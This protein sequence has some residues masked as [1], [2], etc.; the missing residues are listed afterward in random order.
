MLRVQQAHRNIALQLAE[1]AERHYKKQYGLSLP[2]DLEDAYLPFKPKLPE[3][4]QNSRR[5]AN[6]LF[7]KRATDCSVIPPIII[8]EDCETDKPNSTSDD[9]TDNTVTLTLPTVLVSGD[10]ENKDPAND[11]DSSAL[12]DVTAVSDINEYSKSIPTGNRQNVL[13]NENLQ[14][15]ESTITFNDQEIV[16]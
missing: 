2:D 7:D 5:R 15:N 8:E 12:V 3:P 13:S 9:L 11:N 4:K 16:N 1:M 10:C 14:T 6:S